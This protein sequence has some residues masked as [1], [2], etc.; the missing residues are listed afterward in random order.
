MSEVAPGAIAA[1][2]RAKL[3]QRSAG[4]L[5]VGLISAAWG[6]YAHLPAWR[7]L[8]DVEVVGICTSRRET[9]ENAARKYHIER[10]F[11]DYHTLA[12][13]PD[14]DI[15]DCGTRPNWRRDMVLAALDAGKHVY[16]G[17][18]FTESFESS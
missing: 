16:N 8:Q 5:R 10:P 17:I 15:I 9:A 2:S 1:A 6:A 3:P 18:P 11:W 14:I 12:N 13:D 7:S 4:K